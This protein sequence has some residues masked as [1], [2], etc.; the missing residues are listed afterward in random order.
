MKFQK[1]RNNKKS[2]EFDSQ[3][4]RK[5]ERQMDEEKGSRGS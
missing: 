5:I 2:L 1:D 3:I 4:D